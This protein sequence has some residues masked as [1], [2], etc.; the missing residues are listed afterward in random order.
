MIGE[1]AKYYRLS[2]LGVSVFLLLVLFAISCQLPA[3]DATFDYLDIPVRDKNHPV[4][5]QI[6][7]Q[8]SHLSLHEREEVIL[9]EILSGNIP[10]FSRKLIPVK[11]EENN[12]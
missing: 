11:I 5:S 7:N 3:V 12:K 10:S 6:A 8:I 9:E 4:G 2:I 1:L